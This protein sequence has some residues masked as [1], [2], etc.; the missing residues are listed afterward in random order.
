LRP[1]GTTELGAKVEVKN[2]NSFRAVQRAIEFEVE[3]QSAR[4]DAGERIVQET[5][6]YV[7][8]TGET[9]SQR[10]KEEASDYRYFP[11]PDL[12]PLLVTP[13]IV[14]EIRAQLPELPN[15]R[16]ARFEGDLGLTHDEASLL[17]ESRTR[18]DDFEAAV[19]LT[20]VGR[21]RTVA[22]WFMGDVTRLLH[23][24]A[25]DAELGDSQ[26]TPAHIAELVTL[27]EDGEITASTAKEVLEA[28]FESGAMPSAIVTERGLGKVTDEG[29]IEAVAQ[30]V[31]E[32]NP[33]AVEDYRGGKDSAIKFL[34]GQVMRETR[35][36][37]DPNATAELLERLLDGGS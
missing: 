26:L 16:L 20:G 22:H 21:A 34:V 11:E 17:T 28:A 23:G 12:P 33:K 9:A 27:V 19:D 29:A 18:A 35:G 24:V 32:A 1:A 36:Q 25:P 5:R 10:S 2:M 14:E 13:A 31:I 4:L 3:R 7:D 30:G 6:G 37:A 8:A 15:A